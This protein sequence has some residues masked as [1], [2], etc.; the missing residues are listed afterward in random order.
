MDN[1]KEV[2][3][4][5]DIIER[6][7]TDRAKKLGVLEQIKKGWKEKYGTDDVEEIKKILAGLEKEEESTK[8]RLDSI[9]ERLTKDFDWESA[10]RELRCKTTMSL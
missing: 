2:M 7:K 10:E 5:K 1:M 6:L 3:R 8:E 4:I 9:Y